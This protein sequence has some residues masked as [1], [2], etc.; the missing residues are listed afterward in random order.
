VQ[1]GA[2]AVGK[3]LPALCPEQ[4]AV[5]KIPIKQ[6]TLDHIV[7]GKLDNKALLAETPGQR[8]EHIA[9]KAAMRDRR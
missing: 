8:A 9:P 6:K 5:G 7:E 3:L 1:P 4:A 2:L